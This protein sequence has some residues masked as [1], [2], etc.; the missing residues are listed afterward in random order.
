MDD[1]TEPNKDSL[2]KLEY[3]FDFP[4]ISALCCNVIDTKGSIQLLS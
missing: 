4:N 3:Y 2:K 1:D